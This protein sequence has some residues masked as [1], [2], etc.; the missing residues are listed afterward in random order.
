[1]K[2]ILKKILNTSVLASPK[3][4]FQLCKIIAKRV[5]LGKSINIDF[6][7]I[8]ATTLSFLYIVFSNVA[9]ECNKSAKEL[10]AL[11]S[12]SNASYNLIEEMKYLRD[13]YKKLSLQFSAIEYD[14]S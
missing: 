2:L 1:M 9:K 8:Q 10:K 12:I 14:Y 5:K 6:L 4:A 7:G 13:N 11:I 3:K